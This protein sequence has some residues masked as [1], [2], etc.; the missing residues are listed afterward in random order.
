MIDRP[1][2]I[3]M[4]LRGRPMPVRLWLAYRIYR[5]Y[6]GPWEALHAALSVS[7]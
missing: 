1:P 4:L 5:R 3:V 7:R 6:F 2:A